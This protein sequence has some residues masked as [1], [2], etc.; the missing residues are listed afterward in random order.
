M[1][2][3]DMR[4]TLSVV[5]EA[6]AMGFPAAA[7]AAAAAAADGLMLEGGLGRGEGEG[8]RVMVRLPSLEEVREVERE[9]REKQTLHRST[10]H[11]KTKCVCS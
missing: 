7:A 4:A 5:S 10:G 11:T 9:I 2:N 3:K 8:S 6:I 1:M